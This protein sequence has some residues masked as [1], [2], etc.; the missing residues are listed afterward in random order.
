[1]V[2]FQWIL[3]CQDLRTLLISS[4]HPR[5]RKP[6]GE[7]IYFDIFIVVYRLHGHLRNVLVLNTPVSKFGYL[8]ALPTHLIVQVEHRLTGIV[9]RLTNAY[10]GTG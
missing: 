9:T 7:H 3:R 4:Q 1:M 8:N 10:F 2:L 5:M 6:Q